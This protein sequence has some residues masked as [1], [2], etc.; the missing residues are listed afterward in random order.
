MS[1]NL[2]VTNP[3]SSTAQDIQDG[4][5]NSSLAISS[6]KI[7]IG[8]TIPK[9]LLTIS[10]GGSPYSGGTN[11][12]LQLFHNG[13]NQQVEI[14]LGNPT[15]AFTLRYGNGAD[16]FDIVDGGNV[17]RMSIL[18]G[19]NVGIGVTSPGAKLEVKGSTS[20]DTASALKITDSSARSSL[21]IRNDGRIDLG[22]DRAA[23]NSGASIIMVPSPT[24]TAATDRKNIQDAIDQAA[25]NGGGTVILQKGTYVLEKNGANSY[26]IQVKE[27][28]QLIGAGS[29]AT[30]LD[31]GSSSC[32][33]VESDPATYSTYWACKEHIVLKDFCVKA[34]SNSGSYKAIYLRGVL[35]C[36]LENVW[37]NGDN[38]DVSGRHFDTGIHI[39]G[40]VNTLVGCW[41]YECYTG[42]NLSF[43][44]DVGGHPDFT[45]VTSLHGCHYDAWGLTRAGGDLV[46]CYVNG[47]TNGFFGC[48]FEKRLIDGAT[49][50]STIAFYIKGECTN[51]V[52]CHFEWWKTAFKLDTS[53]KNLNVFNCFF[54]KFSGYDLIE[55]NGDSSLLSS[56]NSFYNLYQYEVSYSGGTWNYSASSSVGKAILADLCAEGSMGIGVASPGSKLDVEGPAEES[57]ANYKTSST[58]TQMVLCDSD[59]STSGLK[60]GYRYQSGVTEYA[61]IQAF[62]S[63]NG[64]PISINPNGGSVGI[65]QTSPGSKL[66]VKGS[67]TTSSTSSLNVTDSGDVSKLFVR[68]DGDIAMGVASPSTKLHIKQRLNASN[69]GVRIE[70]SDYSDRYLDVSSSSA[71]GLYATNDLYVQTTSASDIN[72]QTNG[73]STR[74]AVKSDG[75]IGFGLTGPASGLHIAA[76]AG[77]PQKGYITLE[78]LVDGSN[79]PAAPGSG[80]CIIYMRNGHLCTKRGTG[81]EEIIK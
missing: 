12:L 10:D 32:N 78:D 50:N 11:R 67:G 1:T 3:I 19:G 79:E 44:D 66:V 2:V 58:Y 42:Y 61:R 43:E 46:G 76:G 53:C 56:H 65:G 59:T 5:T 28:V 26:C 51:I 14:C 62:N 30:I 6:S 41:V 52:G 21:S 63:A 9:N 40:W 22:Y 48:T 60:I 35:D 27:G 13:A 74:I 24:G 17:E 81:S 23:S 33:V 29:N 80:K 70:S 15:N 57:E 69:T 8:T 37:V 73:N 4:T 39:Q 77:G 75:K 25:Y 68:D 34:G 49:P 20:D 18:N 64:T 36:Y 7:G 31:A 55:H 38:H 71:Q 16:R 45:N 54:A 72:L 47:K